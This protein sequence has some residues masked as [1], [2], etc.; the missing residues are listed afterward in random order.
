[1][2]KSAVKFIAVGYHPFNK[3]AKFSEKLIFLT[4]RYGHVHVRIRGQEML[5]FRKILRTYSGPLQALSYWGGGQYF[6]K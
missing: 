2:A 6:S 3:Y 1:M 4:P 5:V